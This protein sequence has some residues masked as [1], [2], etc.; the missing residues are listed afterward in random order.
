MRSC[1]CELFVLFTIVVCWTYLVTIQKLEN[2]LDKLVLFYY[3][4]KITFLVVITILT[5][6]TIYFINRVLNIIQLYLLGRHDRRDRRDHR[7]RGHHSNQ[8]YHHVRLQ[9]VHKQNRSPMRNHHAQF[10]CHTTTVMWSFIN[11]HFSI[12][13]GHTVA[14]YAYEA[15]QQRF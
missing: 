1:Y 14:S 10:V 12:I 6:A 11:S 9:L 3:G 5:G 4:N 7:R 13:C 15:R 8:V 2:L